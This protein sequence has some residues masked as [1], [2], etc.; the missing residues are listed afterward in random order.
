MAT[1]QTKARQII[2][3]LLERANK[4]VDGWTDETPLWGDGLGLDSLEAAELSAMLEDELGSD[5]FSAGGDLPE[6]VGDVLAFYAG[7]ASE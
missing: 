4:G 5:P 7:T 6:R 1:E 3:E 2:V